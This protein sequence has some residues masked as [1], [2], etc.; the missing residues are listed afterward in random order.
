[1]SLIN[2]SILE[3]ATYVVP[4]GG[5]ALAFAGR[6]A[7]GNT[8]VLYDTAA[9]DART[10]K[11]I[12]CTVK[13]PKPSAGAPNGYT[14]ARTSILMK[15]PLSLDN[16]GLTVN[17]AGANFA[18]DVETTSA[19]FADMKLRLCQCIMDTDFDAFWLNRSLN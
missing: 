17:T 4:T 5:S 8:H 14:Q 9:V 2:A 11:T 7:Q 13:D 6:G 1:M 19:E 16:G 15:D 10:Q 3:G 18:I 12:V